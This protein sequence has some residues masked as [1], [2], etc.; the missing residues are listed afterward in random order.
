MLSNVLFLVFRGEVL[1]EKIALLLGVLESLLLSLNHSL[2]LNSG[3][4]LLDVKT[5]G[6]IEFLNG[7]ISSTETLFSI[8]FIVE[9]NESKFA[10]SILSIFLDKNTI[11]LEIYKI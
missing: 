9:T 6:V 8:A 5:L 11:N 10:I 2:S 4:G 1:D 7:L 3:Q